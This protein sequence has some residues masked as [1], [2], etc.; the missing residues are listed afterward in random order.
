V[1]CEPQPS[2][3]RLLPFALIPNSQ[4]LLL[5]LQRILILIIV[6]LSLIP[7]YYINLW[8]QKVIQPRRSFGRFL[9]YMLAGMGL[10]FGYTFLITSLIFKLFPVPFLK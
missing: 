9:L 3:F 6:L 7:V 2:A 8:M 1:S 4:F 5:K 10:V